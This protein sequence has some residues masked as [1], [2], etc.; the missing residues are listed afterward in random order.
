MAGRQNRKLILKILVIG[1]VIAVL[2]YLFHPDVGQLNLTINGKPV[3][4]PLIRFAA[5]PTFLA[6]L[7]LTAFIS[8]LIFL[9]FGMLMLMIALAMTFMATAF[10]APYFW[11]LL[12]IIFLVV[13][14]S[15]LSHRE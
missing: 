12:A 3:A 8:I 7:A 14:V 9:G 13:A 2:S 4:D 1:F 5:L 15:S 6:L 10:I 11:P